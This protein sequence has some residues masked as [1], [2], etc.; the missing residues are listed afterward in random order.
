[1]S[2][3]QRRLLYLRRRTLYLSLVG[4]TTAGGVAALSE[5][6]NNG[7]LSV[8]ELTILLLFSLAFALIASAFCNAVIGFCVRLFSTDP[9]RYVLPHAAPPAVLK[10]RT[11]VV[12][13]VYNEDPNATL[14][15]LETTFLSLRASGSLAHFELFLLSDSTDPTLAAAERRLWTALCARHPDAVGRVHY[16]HRSH[17]DGRKVGNIADFCRRWGERF[18]FMVVL[19]ADSVMSGATLVKLAGLIQANPQVGIIQT[20]PLP[21]RSQTLFGRVLQFS[22]WLCSEMLATGL[23][24]WQLDDGCYFGHNAIIRLRPFIDHCRLPVLPGKG[25]LAG[26]ILS[27]DFVEAALLRAQGWAVWTLPDGEGSFEELPSNVLD[28]AKRDRRWCQGNLQHLRLL[29]YPGLTLMSR[30]HLLNGAL[31]YLASPL[32]LALIVLGGL[33]LLEQTLTPHAYFAADSLFPIWPVDQSEQALLLFG[34]TLLLL[35]APKLLALALQLRRTGRSTGGRPVVSLLLET[36]FSALL[37]PVLMVF[38]SAF[39]SAIAAGRSISWD[40]QPRG[41]R[42]LSF[43]EAW[44]SQQLQFVTAVVIIV[45]VGGTAPAHLWWLLPV[46][47][48]LLLAAP[49]AVLSSSSTVGRLARRCG[50]FLSPAEQ[51]EPGQPPLDLKTPE[52]A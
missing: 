17:N 50:L 49:L 43:E 30:L 24:Y 33:L 10:T 36:L 3:T 9:C 48:G 7:G 39:I 18:E 19:D 21:V 46:L 44:L 15:R 20:T 5:V 51:A 47:A 27:H 14:A 32:W 4:L 37:A 31:A 42:R 23:C 28:Y 22:G 52:L 38:H 35:L 8:V 1:M 26:E 6:L 12:M 34:A 40:P 41:G 45:A 13:P 11:A 29:R 25:P 16:R 2:K